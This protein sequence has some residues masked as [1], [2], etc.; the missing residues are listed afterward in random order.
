MRTARASPFA[1]ASSSGTLA[2]VPKNISQRHVPVLG[3]Q[4]H[5]FDGGHLGGCELTRAG[6]RAGGPVVKTAGQDGG[7]AVSCVV[8]PGF[9]VD[10]PQDHGEREEWSC[11]CDGAQDPGL[12]GAFGQPL[13]SE[14][15]A[16]SSEHRQ[17]NPDNGRKEALL[18]FELRDAVDQLL[19][20][21]LHQVDGDDRALTTSSPGG[22]SGARNRDVLE[23]ASGAGPNHLRAKTV[24]ICAACPWRGR[25]G[26]MHRQSITRH[27]SPGWRRQRNVRLA[28]ASLSELDR[29]LLLRARI[30]FS[31]VLPA[32]HLRLLAALSTAE[33]G[34]SATI[35]LSVRT[36]LFE[37]ARL[38]GH[39]KN[40]GAPG[41]LVLRRGLS[42][43]DQY[44]TRLISEQLFAPVAG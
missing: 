31:P 26:V 42:S 2:P 37:I 30:G 10:D 6:S 32:D 36:A 29:A 39:I 27:G 38:G 5:L 11:T 25:G 41:W 35:Q 28:Q 43:T 7:A 8:S 12:G 21:L 1:S 44:R 23:Q 4:H 9:E 17:K 15:E 33:T 3:S 19:A 13:A 22:N 24:V 20:V 40:N 34:Q 16:G 14:A 18:P